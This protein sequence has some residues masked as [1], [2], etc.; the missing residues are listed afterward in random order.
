MTDISTYPNTGIQHARCVLALTT[1]QVC[2]D[3]FWPAADCGTVLKRHMDKIQRWVDAC[4]QHTRKKTLS[5]GA[6]RDIDRSFEI[7]GRYMTTEDMDNETRFHR[8]AA[9]IWTTLTFVEDACNTCPAYAH[10]PQWRYLR[11]TVNTLA[12]KLRALEPGIDEDGTAIYEEA[13]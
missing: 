6:R 4:A 12:E 5:A 1:I 8:W 2:L 9:L 11:Q 7:L 10:T 13:A 3:V